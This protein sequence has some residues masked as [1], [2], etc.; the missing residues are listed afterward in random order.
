MH[1]TDDG[2]E[3]TEPKVEFEQLIEVAR[4]ALG[5]GDRTGAEGALTAAIELTDDLDDL[6][7]ERS[8]ALLRLGALKH[9]MGNLAE[10]ERSLRQAIYL[11]RNF[12]LAH[13]HLGLALTKGNQ[14]R[15]AARSFEN[16]LKLSGGV[17]DEQTVEDRDGVTVAGLKQMAALHLQKIGVS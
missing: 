12:L 16:V 17:H 3:M 10:A 9:E 6:Y 1:P 8:D 11:D 5:R 2:P 15:A 7:V 13:Y 4:L 14:P